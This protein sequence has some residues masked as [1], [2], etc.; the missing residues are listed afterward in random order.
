MNKKTDLLII[1]PADKKKI[2]GSLSA[3]LSA[4]EPPLW[5]GLIAAYCRKNGLSVAIIDVEAEDLG[6]EEAAQK[7]KGYVPHLVAFVVTGTNLSASTWNMS[8][9]REY[10][11]ALQVVL[12]GVK[13]L[14]WGLHPS[15]LPER[16]LREEGTD[17]VCQGEGFTAITELVKLLKR[18]VHNNTYDISGLWYMKDGKVSANARPP[19]I[20]DLDALPPVAWDLLPM[21]KY[22]AHNWHCFDDLENRQPYGV[23]YTSLGCPFNCSFCAL[24]TLFG[25]PGIRYRSPGK[26]IEDIDTLVRD[27][28][29][30]NIKVLDECF[31]LKE[32]HVIEICDLIVKRGYDLN[33]WAY[34]RIDTVNEAMLKNMAR[35]GFRWLCYGI[36]SGNEQA[37]SSV[38]KH[39]FTRNDIRN[40]V[41]M[42]KDSGINVLGNFILGLPDEDLAAMEETLAFAIEL[43]CEYTNFYAMMAYPGSQLY[44]E[45]LRDNVRL[46]ETWRGYSAFSSE[47]IPLPT[48]YLSSEEVLAFRDKAFIEFHSNPKY[49]ALIEKKF[50]RKASQHVKGMLE[51]KIERHILSS[52][53]KGAGYDHK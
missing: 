27:Y 6:P 39:G 17:F 9:A 28:R 11:K 16:T 34:A 20:K 31:A 42:T 3:S 30:K 12:A 43:N 7:A 29:V 4:I 47:C 19:L 40:V 51:H 41:A 22:R 14:L 49:L 8:G 21:E 45:A 35:A 44:E 25:A 52:S 48:K 18:G 32:S 10:I 5:A 13:T 37:L 2:Y 38:S 36:E 53:K 1:K 23:I 15:A 46:P 26:V 24:R 50:G 33:I